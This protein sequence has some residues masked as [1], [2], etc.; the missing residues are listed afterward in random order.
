[1]PFKHRG[2]GQVA[3]AC[4]GAGVNR[5]NRRT[6]DTSMPSRIMANSVAVSSSLRSVGVGKW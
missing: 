1:M 2:R 6:W 5:L 3:R 4:T